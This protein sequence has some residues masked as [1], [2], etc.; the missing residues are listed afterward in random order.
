MSGT[1]VGAINI[2]RK[3][4]SQ[5]FTDFLWRKKGDQDRL[6]RMGRINLDKGNIL[7]NYTIYFEAIRG[8][9]S[10]SVV[11]IDDISITEEYCG[12]PYFCNFEDDLCGWTNA[13]NNV[14]DNFDWL[15][16]SGSTGSYLTGPSVDVCLFFMNI[17]YISYLFM[18][19][20]TGNPW[21]QIWMV[22]VYR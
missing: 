2:F 19:L 8:K 13:E 3:R 9:S 15:R 16:N 6:W 7:D 20:S 21:H 11:A 10:Q 12:S 18:I 1:D 22:Y 14:D 4:N 17:M 5:S